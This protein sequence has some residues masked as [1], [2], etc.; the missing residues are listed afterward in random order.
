MDPSIRMIRNFFL[1]RLSV[2]V[3]LFLLPMVA[4]AQG[5]RADYARADSLDD[6]TANKSFRESVNPHWLVG[7]NSFW[8]ANALTDHKTEYVLV[9]ALKGERTVVPER[10][11]GELMPLSKTDARVSRSDSSTHVV[12]RFINH[13]GQEAKLL[14]VDF[15]GDHESYGTVKN[16]ASVEQNTYEGHVWWVEGLDGTPLGVFEAQDSASDAV[17]EPPA[18][19]TS[20]KNAPEVKAAPQVWQAF[21]R[22][23]NVWTK[24]T[25]T[26]QEAQLS[27]DGTAD[28][29][30]EEPF[31]FSPDGSKLVVLQ[32]KPAQNHEVYL[33]ESSPPDQV[34]PKL[35]HYD[36]LKPGDRIA[37]PLPR[38]FDLT[39]RQETPIPDD[40]FPNPWDLDDF[41]WA[42][43][44]SCFYFSYN[45]RGHQIERVI[46][47]DAA[48]GNARAIVVE[49]SD[50]FIDY[51]QKFYLQYLDRTNEL[52]WASERDGLNHYYLIDAKTGA[53][54]S[55]ITPDPWIVR[56]VE[57]VDEDKRQAF[58]RVMG[59]PG[60]DPYHFHLARVNLDGTGFTLLTP[61]DG[62]HQ[63]NWSPDGRFLVDTWSRVD[64]PPVTVL[65]NADGAQ[66]CDLEHADVSQL[67]ATG[68]RPPQRFVA[69][70]RDGTTD[71]YGILYQPSNFDPA[72]HYPVIE[73][74]YAGPQDFAVPK[75]WR[76]FSDDQTMAELGFIVV[77]IDG[78]G[79]NWRSK[80]FH[81]VCW[82]NLKDA[83]LPDRIAWMR[84]AATT[85]PWMD[86][87]RV[88]I[89]GVSAGGQSALGAMLF[90]GDFYKA[91]VADSGCHDNR[92]DKIWWN[93]Q[94]MG[95]PVGPQYADSSNVTHAAQLNGPLLLMVGELDHNVDP[96]STMQVVNALI[97]ADKD[98]DLIVFPGA[99]HAPGDSPYG[100]RRRDD[101]FVRHLL[102][103][104]PRS[105]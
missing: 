82:Q 57:S 103:V 81:D 8:Y 75:T 74:I 50:T 30:Y 65:R 5:T 32:T 12:L 31:Y 52:I 23:N 70:G 71:I 93:E 76:R 10:P 95:W 16:G 4:W 60:E 35:E 40:L 79:T 28:D 24:N 55:K 56:S 94:W 102:G 41:H 20:A 47:V 46:S 97:K 17:I 6:R 80:A 39:T 59:G 29:P 54:K 72:R 14:W 69:K 88:G 9:D 64:Q 84:A 51:S 98:F 58:L 45:Q 96:A 104:E 99:D 85:R 62:T 13:S 101:F 86:L 89:Y 48:T 37:H 66:I 27:N 42:P 1:I 78:M 63:W 90:H 61:G 26:G 15:D 83:G 92:M 43:D 100:Y 44:N 22:K 11:T 53:V 3:A 105:S 67:L 21:I 91:A 2:H 18:P 73:D 77:Q 87:T 36:Y 19:D 25:Q 7:G 33:I 49:K 68:W 34:Q 38:L